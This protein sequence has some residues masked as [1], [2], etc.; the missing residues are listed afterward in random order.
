ML[1]LLLITQVEFLDN[2]LLIMMMALEKSL[3]MGSINIIFGQTVTRMK[4]I[5]GVLRTTSQDSSQLTCRD[6]QLETL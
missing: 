3:D 4:L 6:L 2:Q 5:L 1:I